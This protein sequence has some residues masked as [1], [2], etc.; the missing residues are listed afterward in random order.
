MPAQASQAATLIRGLC[1]KV[2][3][4]IFYV[5]YFLHVQPAL[6]IELKYRNCASVPSAELQNIEKQEHFNSIGWLCVRQQKKKKKQQ[7][8]AS[9]YNPVPCEVYLKVPSQLLLL[10]CLFF[11][12]AC[13]PYGSCYVAT[14]PFIIACNYH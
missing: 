12:I 6:S 4:N 14:I 5:I 10:F 8:S 1:S 13:L 9:E 3:R 11:Y 2:E 7:I